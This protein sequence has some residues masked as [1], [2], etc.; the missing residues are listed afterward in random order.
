MTATDRVDRALR[1]PGERG[2]LE[3]E[4]EVHGELGKGGMGTVLAARD[5][6]LCRSVAVK[7]LAPALRFDQSAMH[8]FVLEAQ[9]VAQLEHPNIVPIY[10]LACDE[11]GKPGFSMRLVEG[12]SFREYLD[13][14][15]T[16]AKASA[17]EPHD[18][19]SRLERFLKACDAIEYAHARG[20]VHRDLK[21]ENIMLGEHNEVYVVDWGL[22]K[23]TAP[24]EEV[25]E[26]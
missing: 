22:A 12:E 15:G 11:S 17:T 8:R 9:V 26:A 3:R 10:G 20:V 6:R 25:A 5:L 1:E 18:L 16:S 23:V 21:P 2:R 24:D 13:A 14:C 19:D 4:F 7:V